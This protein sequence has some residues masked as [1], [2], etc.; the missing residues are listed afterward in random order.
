[1][2]IIGCTSLWL[3]RPSMTGTGEIMSS[4][5]QRSLTTSNDN[6]TDAFSPPFTNLADITLFDGSDSG[7]ADNH[8]DWL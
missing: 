1:M 5:A 4:V 7:V 2:E 3:V 6:A 8:G